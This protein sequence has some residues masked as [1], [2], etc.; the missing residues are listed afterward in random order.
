[1]AKTIDDSVD[2]AVKI[3]DDL[4]TITTYRELVKSQVDLA[5]LVEQS[6]AGKVIPK[7]VKVERAY[8]GPVNIYADSTSIRRCIDNL[9]KNAVEAMPQ[10]GVL[11]IS[12]HVKEK[13]VEFAVKDTGK[14]LSAEVMKSLFNPF[15]STK[16]I[17]R[18]LGLAFC[19]GAV[20]AHGGQVTVESKVEEGATF[21]VIL[22]M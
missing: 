13:S 2:Y 20:E 21:T 11:T 7:S 12:I 4:R 6:L 18:G 16:S 1:M 15:F 3:L 9:V 10:G 22:P 5:E 8:T 19:K 17:E 14:G